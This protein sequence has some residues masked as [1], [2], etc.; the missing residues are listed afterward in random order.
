MDDLTLEFVFRSETSCSFDLYRPTKS[1][2]V[3]GLGTFEY[4]A[5]TS[6]RVGWLDVH[7]PCDGI[8]PVRVR[9]SLPEPYRWQSSIEGASLVTLDRKLTQMVHS[10]MEQL[11]IP[12]HLHFTAIFQLPDGAYSVSSDPFRYQ[13]DHGLQLDDRPEES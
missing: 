6:A 1:V 3:P 2:E 13:Y 7:F 11:R 9:A 4:G 12:T 8:T 10:V 5:G